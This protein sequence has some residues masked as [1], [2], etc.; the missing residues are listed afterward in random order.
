MQRATSINLGKGHVRNFSAGSAK[1]L[2][3]TPRS[4]V[5]GKRRSVEPR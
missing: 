4:S 3:L 2:N 1:L 5:D